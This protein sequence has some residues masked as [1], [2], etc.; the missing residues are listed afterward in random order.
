MFDFTPN[1]EKSSVQVP[2]YEDAREKDGWKGQ[3]TSKSITT[4]QNEITAAISRL[5]GIVSGFQRGTF[6]VENV[7]R[8]G[9]QVHYA[10]KNPNGQYIPGRIDIAALPT[11]S[12]YN[13]KSKD[14]SLRMSLFMLR[15]GLEGMWLMQQLSPGYAA[16][17]PWM[18]GQDGKTITQLWQESSVMGKLLPPP[19]SDFI[20]AEVV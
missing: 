19:S 13:E 10:L 9:F 20:E 1:E 12:W 3:E 14:K 5:G 2:Y 18:I 4:L 8:E 11:K 16:L 7:K 6:N 15:E 17:M